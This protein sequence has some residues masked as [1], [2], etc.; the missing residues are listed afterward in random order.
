MLGTITVGSFTYEGQDDL[1]HPINC[2]KTY[3]NC[4]ETGWYSWD[5]MNYGEVPDFV[6]YDASER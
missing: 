5:Y 3:D 6:V 1:V 2:Y 4:D